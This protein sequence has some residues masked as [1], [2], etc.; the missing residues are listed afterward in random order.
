MIVIASH[1]KLDILEDLL[2]SIYES[3]RNGHEVLVY[4]TNSKNKEYLKGINELIKK[5]P[6]TIYARSGVD[7]YEMGAWMYAYENFPSE[8]YFFIHD[9]TVVVRKDFFVRVDGLLREYDVVPFFDFPYDES[10]RSW[11]NDGIPVESLPERA[12]FGSMFAATKNI[13]DSIPKKWLQKFRAI[14][15]VRVGCRE[16]GLL[17]FM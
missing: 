5:F 2:I 4:D 3:D 7:C 10:H 6:G 11:S 16:G 1:D 8:T 14:K 12:I 13:L 15:K 17:C 9:S